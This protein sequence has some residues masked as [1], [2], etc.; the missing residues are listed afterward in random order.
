M[1]FLLAGNGVHFGPGQVAPLNG[2]FY[3]S[4]VWASFVATSLSVNYSS[5]R[6]R[7]SLTFVDGGHWVGALLVQGFMIGPM[8]I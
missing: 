5:Q 1:G 7:S 8:D 6:S 4:F 2:V 3:G